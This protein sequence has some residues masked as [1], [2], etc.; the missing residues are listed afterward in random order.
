MEVICEYCGNFVDETAKNCPHCSATNILHLRTARDTPKTID[1]LWSWYKDHINGDGRRPEEETR[2]FIGKDIAPGLTKE[3]L[4]FGIYRDGE[5]VVVYKNKKDGTRSIRYKGTDEAYAVNEFLDRLKQECLHQRELRVKRA[6][7]ILRQG[8]SLNSER[9]S[10]PSREESSCSVERSGPFGLEDNPSKS[11]GTKPKRLSAL[12]FPILKFSKIRLSKPDW[13]KIFSTIL[14]HTIL[15]LVIGA[16]LGLL[17]GITAGLKSLLNNPKSGYYYLEEENLYYDYGYNTQGDEHGYEWWKY[18]PHNDN[19]EV[20][21]YAERAKEFPSP[22][23]KKSERSK[24]LPFENHPEY[25]YEKYNI[26]TSRGYIDVHHTKPTQNYY[27]CGGDTYYFL[28]DNKGNNTGWYVYDDEDESWRFCASYDDKGAIA[29]DLWYDPVTYSVT[30]S[31]KDEMVSDF[32]DTSYYQEYYA[33]NHPSTSHTQQS[34]YDDDDYDDWP[35]SGSSGWGY[36]GWDDDDDS[37]GSSS[38]WDWGYSG[39]DS[40]TSYDSGS[41]WDYGDSGWDSGSS[42]WGSDWDSGGSYDYGGWDYGDSGWDSGST[43]W[44]SD[45]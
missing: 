13:N 16:V 39:W 19:W 5:N 30:F 10:R 43:D 42:D 23:G 2:F 9:P 21:Y 3:N 11:E 22:L 38:S 15:L 18:N 27:I 33:A 40:G 31:E 35:S 4:A 36:S 34:H 28:D 17:L 32:E 26:E 25:T 37:S 8:R 41:S 7:E 14:D 45:W 6:E 12:R 44:S 20:F 1:E 29:E 24:S